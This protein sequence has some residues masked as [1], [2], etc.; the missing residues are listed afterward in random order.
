[1]YCFSTAFF[2]GQYIWYDTF[3]V[4][5]MDWNGNPIHAALL[6][7]TEIDNLNQFANN[8]KNQDFSNI[9]QNV[10]SAAYVAWQL[11]TILLG[12]YIFG[13]LAIFGIPPMVIIILQILYLLLLAR[14]ILAYVR[15]I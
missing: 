12:T 14:A 1:M 4:E 9:T 6:N 2:V 3:H 10:T 13:I 7:A 15:G 11:L 8:V 5:M